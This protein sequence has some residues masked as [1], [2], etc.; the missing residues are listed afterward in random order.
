MGKLGIATSVIRDR[1]EFYLI[2]ARIGIPFLIAFNKGS[3]AIAKVPLGGCIAA[4]DG[5]NIFKIKGML[6]KALHR[7]SVQ[8]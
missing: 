4:A 7:I 2:T 1:N 6:G 3:T 5:R 8:F